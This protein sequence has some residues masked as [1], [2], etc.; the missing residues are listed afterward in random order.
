[1][2]TH[3]WCMDALQVSNTTCA[4]QCVVHHALY[5]VLPADGEHVAL[6]LPLAERAKL[7]EVARAHDL[8]QLH[9]RVVAVRR[10]AA[11]ALRPPAPRRLPA[12]GLGL[13][14]H[15]RFRAHGCFAQRTP[16]LHGLP[17]RAVRQRG[18]LPRAP[19]FAWKLWGVKTGTHRTHD[20]HTAKLRM[21][22]RYWR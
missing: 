15:A 16:G 7:L 17:L 22:A 3:R 1:M 18:C 8:P 9:L 2:C 12:I 20:R 14:R 5:Y 19:D 21:P 13:R 10:G 6:P 11:P 4:A